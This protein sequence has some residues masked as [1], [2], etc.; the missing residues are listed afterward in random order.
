MMEEKMKQQEKNTS[1]RFKLFRTFYALLK[2]YDY[3]EL[4]RQNVLEAH[5]VKSLNEL[6]IEEL[7]SE[8]KVMKEECN[9]EKSKARRRVLAAICSYLE[10]TEYQPYIEA[11]DR[12]IRLIIAKS[13][14]NRAAGVE[15]FNDIPLGKLRALYGF[16]RTQVKVMRRSMQVV[17]D[18]INTK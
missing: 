14:A 9:D 5:S 10:E 17:N 1:K 8:V 2:N 15:W 18:I 7:E 3:P 12:T 16:F 11:E 6:T 13:I 4:K